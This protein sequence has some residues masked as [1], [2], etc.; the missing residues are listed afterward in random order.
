ML[1]DPILN[2]TEVGRRHVPGYFFGGGIFSSAFLCGKGFP[3]IS[4]HKAL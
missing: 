4:V 1:L 3:D 2:S